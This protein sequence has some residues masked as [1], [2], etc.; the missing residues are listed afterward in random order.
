MKQIAVIGS[1][2]NTVAASLIGT[3]LHQA[4]GWKV[5]VLGLD[6]KGLTLR[7]GLEQLALQGYDCAVAALG[8]EAVDQSFQVGVL[9]D[10]SD[11]R[12]PEAVDACEK[13]VV[14]L[15]D[16][17]G[18][19]M[20]R[21]FPALTYSERKDQAD[22]TAKNLRCYPNRTEF[23]ALTWDDIQRVRMPVLGGYDIYHGLA[24][25]GCGLSL[26]FSLDTLAPSM[27]RA[28]GVPGHLEL[29][30]T[31]EPFHLVVDRANRAMELENLLLTLLPMR[32]KG[33]S[34]RLLTGAVP[35]EERCLAADVADGLADEVILPSE[36][37]SQSVRELLSRGRA[38]DVLVIAGVHDPGS[39]EDER[40]MAA[41]W[42]QQKKKNARQQSAV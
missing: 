23:E 42:L 32:G 29:I 38:G 15:D 40:L 39:G 12:L 1:R 34:L 8:T 41:H 33:G 14:N 6:N 22:L 21:Q 30:P 11:S 31:E 3:M 37:R 4:A 26:G 17:C 10:W 7:A 25:L 2:G 35:E 16:A 9:T 5:G 36:D 28:A 27:E 20:A 18:Q 13:L 24:A 19:Q